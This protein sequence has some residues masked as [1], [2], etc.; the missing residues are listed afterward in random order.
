MVATLIFGEMPNSNVLDLPEEQI[1][2][3]NQ[4]IATNQKLENEPR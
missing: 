4:I 2:V 1:A 3:E